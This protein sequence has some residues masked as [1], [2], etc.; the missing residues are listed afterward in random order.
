MGTI[1]GAGVAAPF[2]RKR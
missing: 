1:A 2:T